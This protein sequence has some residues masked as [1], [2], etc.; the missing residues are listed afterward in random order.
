MVCRKTVSC[1]S[2]KR[3]HQMQMTELARSAFEKLTQMGIPVTKPGPVEGDPEGTQFYLPY[4]SC[5]GVETYVD[6]SRKWLIPESW[7]NG[8][9]IN[10]NGIRHDIVEVLAEHGLWVEQDNCS[11]AFIVE[12]NYGLSYSNYSKELRATRADRIK[13]KQDGLR[14]LGVKLLRD[15]DPPCMSAVA[16]EA[17]K[18]LA[19][20]GAPVWD[21]YRD[22]EW[23]PPETV[24]PGGIQFVMTVE[25]LAEHCFADRPGSDISRFADTD[26]LR[27]D[28]QQVV[29]KYNLAWEYYDNVNCAS[30]K[31]AA[32]NVIAFMD[33][34][35]STKQRGA[36]T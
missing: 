6:G 7:V 25:P 36:R 9:Y 1:S 2:D 15:P 11:V 19:R 28:V 14:K 27:P 21:L 33:P 3:V 29:R 17:M 32:E 16:F 8:E 31:L 35:A 12:G 22:S 18:D 24:L 30:L 10:P 4:A 5:S 26:G 13:S 34:N 20:C 23:C